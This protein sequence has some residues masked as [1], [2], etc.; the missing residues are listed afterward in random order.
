MRKIFIALIGFL[1]FLSC[2]EDENSRTGYLEVDVR[3]TGGAS[4]WE[5]DGVKI[6]LH[7]INTDGLEQKSEWI[8]KTGK[9][10]IE[11]PFGQYRLVLNGNRCKLIDTDSIVT[12]NAGEPTPKAVS[13][14]HLGYS[15]VVKYKDKEMN[16]GDTITFGSGAALD[17]WNKYSSNDLKWTAKAFS[18]SDWIKFTKDNGTILG[19]RTDYALFEITDLPNYGTNYAEIIIATEDE[20]TFTIVVGIFK[21][22]G[23]PQKA[24][25]TGDE[26]NIC[27]ATNVILTA[28][29]SDAT[30]YKWYKGNTLI[31]EEH[32]D[33]YNV[34]ST[35][36][37]SV[38]GVNTNGEGV[39]SDGKHITIN[40]CDTPPAKATIIG[41]NENI[42]P[43]TNVI[44]T[45]NAANATSYKWYKGNNIISGENG[46]TFTVTQTGTYYAVGVNT[47]GIG[48]QSDGKAVTISTCVDIP[49]I[50]TI[51][52]NSTNNCSGADGLTVTLTANAT[53][54]TS[55]IW[56]KGNQQL[57]E[58]GNTLVVGETGTYYVTGVNGSGVG[59]ESVGKSVTI[60]SCMPT[61]P[62]NV[63]VEEFIYTS[64]VGSKIKLSWNNV[65]SATQ[66]KIQVCDNPTMNGC[67]HNYYT[68]TNSYYYFYPNDL[69]CGQKYFKIIAVNSFGESSG[70]PF[71]YMMPV[72]ITATNNLYLTYNHAT[73]AYIL[74]YIDADVKWYEGVIY[75]EIQRKED[76]GPWKIIAT[77]TGNTNESITT[78]HSYQDYTYSKDAEVLEYRVRTYINTDCG[79]IEDYAY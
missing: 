14:E 18:K 20:G 40:S 9:Q 6:A 42:C 71:S 79:V 3:Y 77:I 50:A 30:S 70:T 28:N 16:S 74:S 26:E 33:K 22:G 17:I 44:L 39:K 8:D 35:G 38:I 34:T 52:G 5:L 57:N 56:R 61:N 63:K 19:N 48:V 67:D 2:N 58:T 13:I 7:R 60:T 36:T 27:P 65:S 37:Y 25:I 41:E 31:D 12:I 54:A 78:T 11:L 45:A 23:E 59:K 10:R 49:A 4:Q 46:N 51:S 72:S 1:L 15:V 68:T 32:T 69:P 75:F 55:Y 29:A 66:Y 21:S 53:R 43:A 47:N 24:A 73:Q 76:D 64:M 62:T